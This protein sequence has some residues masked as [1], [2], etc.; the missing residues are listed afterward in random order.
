MEEQVKDPEVFKKG[1][2]THQGCTRGL[3]LVPQRH[4]GARG[5]WLLSPLHKLSLPSSMSR[6]KD[7]TREKGDKRREKDKTLLAPGSGLV[8]E[9]RLSTFSFIWKHLGFK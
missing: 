8:P 5:L 4:M 6:E 2:N 7:K 9:N 1:W 3:L